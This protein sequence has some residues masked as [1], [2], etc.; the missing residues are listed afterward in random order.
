[1]SKH[2]HASSSSSSSAASSV[3]GNTPRNAN[4]SPLSSRSG[5]PGF[6]RTPRLSLARGSSAT[7]AGGYLLLLSGSSSGAGAGGGAGAHP[8]TSPSTTTPY[9]AA[10]SGVDP[11]GPS[12][13]SPRPAA[14]T[15]V[16]PIHRS[17]VGLSVSPGR[18]LL[19]TG[20]SSAGGG[21]GGRGQN[22]GGGG[23]GGA[24]TPTRSVTPSRG[25]AS[26][27]GGAVGLKH[28]GSRGSLLAPSER[29]RESRSPATAQA[30]A[31]GAI[32]ESGAERQEGETAK[33]A[34]STRRT[35]EV[36][37]QVG[38][39]AAGGVGGGADR[40]AGAA[41]KRDEPTAQK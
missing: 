25:A 12:S 36:I 33:P 37:P 38:S 26:G 34:L 5:A 11:S 20:G 1:M 28:K 8:S 41:D 19:H 3:A 10:S 31:N 14:A 27:A 9:T 4:V 22:Q 7:G 13:L 18:A 24:A 23:G 16:S 6:L 15:A 17:T 2:R 32:A 30:N 29:E 39:S 35:V 21:W 40:E